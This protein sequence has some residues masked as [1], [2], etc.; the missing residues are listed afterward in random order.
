MNLPNSLVKWY[1]RWTF[2]R[3]RQFM[4][5]PHEAQEKIF[6]NLIQSAKNTEW[7][8]RYGYDSIK[9]PGAYRQ[10]VPISQYDDLKPYIQR[11]MF[12]EQDVLW[13]GRVKWFSKSSGTTSDKSKFI[14][15]P[16]ENLVRCHHQGSRDAVAMW[17]QDN[18]N[19]RLLAGGKSLIMGGSHAPF[20]GNPSTQVGD[21]SAIMLRHLPS[22]A[23]YFHTPDIQ[24]SLMD[25][26][27]SKIER[28]AQLIIKENITNVGGVPTWTLV[29][30]RRILEIT[31]KDNILEVFPNFE[32]YM[33]GGVSF[34]PYREQFQKLLPGSQVQYR[35]IYNATEG[36]FGSQL[37]KGDDG[38]LLLLD[39]GVYYEFIPLGELNA[40]HPR[41]LPLHEV[42]AG[43]S[44]AMVV[45]TNAGL[46][47]YLIGDTVR[48]TS[49]NPYKIVVS[50]RTKHFI[51]A[52]GEEVMVENTDK[53]LSETCR[54]FGV[55]AKEYTVAPIYMAGDGGKGGHEW[56]IEF[57]TPPHDLHSFTDALD[58]ALQS[59]NSDYE[60]KRYKSIA[61]QR[62]VLRV[63]PKDTF[64]K[65]MKNK[66]KYGG[67]HKVPRLANDRH[68]V[69]EI[70]G[71][72]EEKDTY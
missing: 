1:S 24:T 60:A 47:R 57:E 36:F 6:N 16:A 66:G 50:G 3:I 65:W 72:L 28:M 13:R 2:Q 59:I 11:M 18:P 42:Q 61:L 30:F 48:F 55:Q 67:Q 9:T 32:L 58:E 17:Y 53:A 34:S 54:K 37:S 21:V 12:G 22:Y 45:S 10:R 46:W 7:G 5:H 29:L 70:L 49:T 25:E 52:F 19:S 68:Y 41:A 56:L 62:L 69:D 38:M 8:K 35:E 64:Y 15:V 20:P 23:R 33:H 40:P 71:M 26:W 63:M 51:N 39:N 27:E 44:Y 31:G 14:P 43:E 4:L